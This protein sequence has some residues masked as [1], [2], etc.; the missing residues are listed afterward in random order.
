VESLFFEKEEVM[1]HLFTGLLALS[2]VAL[3][4]RA[5]DD[6][7]KE[8]KQDFKSIYQDAIKSLGK[9]KTTEDRAKVLK[10]VSPKFLKFAQDNPKDQYALNALGLVVNIGQKEKDKALEILTKD[11]ATNEK[12]GGVVGMLGQS[13]ASANGKKFL[14]AVME[15]NEDKK[16]KGQA[17]GALASSAEMGVQQSGLLANKDYR[18]RQEKQLG[19]DAVKTIINNADTYKKDL[20]TY[21]KLVKDKYPDAVKAPFLGTK[22]K[23]LTSKDLKDKEVKLS[24]LKGKVV[25]L[26]IWATWCPPCRAMIPHERELVKRLKDKSFALVSISADAKKETLEKFLEDTPMPWTHWWNGAKGGILSDLGVQFYP[27]IYILD[28]KGVVRFKNLRGKDMDVAVDLLVKEQED[29]KK[30][31]T[32]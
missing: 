15:K 25:V 4:V 27:T 10:E 3:G 23:D 8:D 31:K 29:E 21:S 26:D 14:T 13:P 1:R 30:A 20:A 19:K 6:E 28:H 24:D 5:A 12:I 9:A 11:H 18:E 17:A 7:K 22:M 16:I 2:I 32:E